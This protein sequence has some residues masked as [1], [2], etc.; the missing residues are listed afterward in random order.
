M[1]NKTSA[2]APLPAPVNELNEIP[3]KRYKV[4]LD[5]SPEHRWTEV[6]LDNISRLTRVMDELDRL[7]PSGWI[8]YGVESIMA[9][10]TYMNIVYY[11]AE[12]RA[13]STITKIPLGKLVMLQLYYE[14]NAHCTSIVTNSKQGAC[15]TRTMDWELPLLKQLTIEVEFMKGGRQVFVA[16][17]W[18]GCVGIFTGMKPGAFAVSLNYRRTNDS[19]A[20][21]VAKTILYAWPTSFLIR[22]VLTSAQSYEE[23]VSVLSNSKIIAPCYFIIASADIDID[24]NKMNFEQKSSLYPNLLNT[25]IDLSNN[26]SNDRKK[27]RG[28]I[29]IRDRNGLALLKNNPEKLENTD[30]GYVVQTNHDKGTQGENI[31]YS[32]ER[33]IVLHAL[34]GQ[35]LIDDP[36]KLLDNLTDYPIINEETIYTTQMIPNQ[37]SLKTRVFK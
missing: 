3:V 36:D 15:L 7:I 10:A 26:Q 24:A 14:L 28:C 21:N 18:V 27:A 31:I 9:A 29:L 17:T 19:V 5:L 23:A 13:I 12:L 22:E 33:V 32:R 30:D 8:S 11:S 2:F 34:M 4:S 35:R 1:S 16:T 37:G 25:D 6:V 20:L